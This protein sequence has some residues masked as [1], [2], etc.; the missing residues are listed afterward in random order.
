MEL[1]G[2]AKPFPS[3]AM[4]Y[5]CGEQLHCTVVGTGPRNILLLHGFAASVHTWDELV[6]LFP[7]DQYTL[8]LIDLKGHGAST[9]L[10]GDDYSPQHNA[11]LAASYIRSRGLSNVTLIGHSLGGAVGLLC[12]LDCP[13]ITRLILLG[14]P[15]FPQQIPRFMRIL[16]LPF[17][18]PLLMSALPAEKIARK[19]LE[20]VFYRQ[21]R[22][23]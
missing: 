19:G 4:P 12:A 13:D 20:A 1:P 6:P 8:H 7:A 2:P 18:G 9:T 3:T 16:R 15:A 23:T 22:I 10:S 11:R 5:P 17:L 14:A 21:E